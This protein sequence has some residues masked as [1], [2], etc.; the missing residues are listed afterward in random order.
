MKTQDRTNRIPHLPTGLIAA[1]TTALLLLAGCSGGG[2]SSGGGSGSGTAW[3]PA[4]PPATSQ[5]NTYI[6]TQ[7][8]G[9]YTVTID[10]TKNTYSYQD[11]STGAAVVSGTFTTAANGFLVLST[12]GGSPAGYAL[13]QL[14]RVVVL[15]PN[16]QYQGNFFSITNNAIFAIAAPSCQVIPAKTQFEYL[17]MAS[18]YSS[19]D[20]AGTIYASTDSGGANWTFGG[21]LYYYG[22]GN[23]KSITPDP[24]TA[25]CAAGSAGSA[26][27]QTDLTVP[28]SIPA[29]FAVGP[30]GFFV[31]D[32]YNNGAKYGGY[33]STSGISFIGAV[34]PASPVDLSSLKG[35]TFLGMGL[36][37]GPTPADV[38]Q[39]G[40]PELVSFSA[41]PDSTGTSI[42][43]TG[44]PFP[45]NDPTQAPGG[46]IS[47]DLGAQDANN[48]GYFPL[49]SA[50]LSSGSGPGTQS[51]YALVSNAGG[52]ATILVLADTGNLYVEEWILFQQ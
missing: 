46:G 35:A 34:T 17:G 43:L 5:V 13:E 3:P 45:S 48:N 12:A 33:S 36:A 28:T 16:T 21:E 1:A 11:L 31:E 4:T 14:S 47:L 30:T 29:D 9:L 37:G 24:F 22:V 50:T 26:V 19:T 23:S 40:A 27:I 49:A 7:S 32:N 52:K 38:P 51:A 25:A 44:G 2:N 8:P 18:P 10:H 15:N 41:A 6:G 42:V 20:T 39:L